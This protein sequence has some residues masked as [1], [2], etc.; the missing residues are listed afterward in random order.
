[1]EKSFIENGESSPTKSKLL[2][3]SDNKIDE[4]FFLQ[5]PLQ[6]I[7]NKFCENNMQDF[8]FHTKVYLDYDKSD[9]YIF[10]FKTNLIFTRLFDEKSK[11]LNENPIIYTINFKQVSMFFEKKICYFNLTINEND[12]NFISLQFYETDFIKK[13]EM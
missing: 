13:S 12:G 9:A 3:I 6:L 10:I 7:I 2:Q 4:L 8:L 1:M 11:E 5:A